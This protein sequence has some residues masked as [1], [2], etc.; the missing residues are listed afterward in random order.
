VSDQLIRWCC[1]DRLSWHSLP[2]ICFLTRASHVRL[3]CSFG[4][5]PGQAAPEHDKTTLQCEPTESFDKYSRFQANCA[6]WV[7]TYTA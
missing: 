1:I 2:D 5:G 4:V 3:M 7:S 6:P